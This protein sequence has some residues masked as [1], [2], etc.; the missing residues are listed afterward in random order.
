M[1]ELNFPLMYYFCFFLLKKKPK[2]VTLRQVGF[3]HDYPFLPAS[4][5][6]RLT[7]ISMGVRFHFVLYN[8][9]LKIITVVFIYFK[10]KVSCSIKEK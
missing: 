6:L 1:M 4:H 5:M 8:N 9:T 7:N 2:H 10:D 3:K